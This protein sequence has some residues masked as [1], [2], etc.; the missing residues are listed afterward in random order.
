MTTINLRNYYP[1]YKEDTFIEVSNEIAEQLRRFNLDDEAYRIRVLR[2]KAYFSLDCDD[3]IENDATS[4]PETPDEIL[5]RALTA[6]LLNEA[7]ALL[8]P[9]QARRVYAHVVLGK[10]KKEI[11]ATEHITKASA[12]E[13]IE[14]GLAN[15]KKLLKKTF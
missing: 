8:S 2:A 1:F 13:S 12:N 11:A 10:S 3:G 7:M 4:K 14:R 15:L 9:T 6:K 5:E